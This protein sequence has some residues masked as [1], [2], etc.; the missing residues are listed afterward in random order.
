MEERV[1]L[2]NRQDR[3]IG[4]MEKQ[5]A[6]RTGSLHRAFSI[7]IFNNAGELLLQKRAAGKYHSGGLWSNTCCSHPT[8]GERTHYA[9]RR[10]LQEEMKL[11]T[12][13]HY[14]FKFLYH[15]QVDDNMTE[16]EI[17]HVFLGE[18][19]QEPK[20]NYS[21]AEEW[22]YVHPEIVEKDIMVNPAH[23]TVWFRKCLHQV[24]NRREYFNGIP[25]IKGHRHSVNKMILL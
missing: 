23:Y 6:H 10:R 24:I 21:E 18:S 13:L 4:V 20:V 8:P 7:F 19:D 9:A 2:I 3:Q 17:D 11:T 5:Q 15:A 12:E 14:A 16:H 1:I 25:S 22:K